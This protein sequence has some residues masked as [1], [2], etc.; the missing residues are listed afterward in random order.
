MMSPDYIRQGRI[1]ERYL[2]G[3]LTVR[4]ARE[5]EKYCLEHPEVLN[6]LPIPVRLKA[7]LARQPLEHSET[8]MFQTIPSSATRAAL[9]LADA[10]MPAEGPMGMPGLRLPALGSLGPNGTRMLVLGLLVALLAAT[11]G[12]LAYGM[13]A[14]S[15]A[16]E[17]RALREAERS[18]QLQPPATVETLRLQMSRTR[19]EQPTAVVGRS[20][21]P[22]LLEL[23]VDATESP[24]N[25]YQVTI[26]R[27]DGTRIM[28]IRRLGRDSNRQLRLALNSSAFGPGEYLLRFDGYTWRGRAEEVGWV[29]LDL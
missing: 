19:P 14:R 25:N 5:F 10:T 2:S 12:L 27:I 17:L 20:I 7:R 6:A 8:G 9:E 29:R 15:L 3:E 16:T 13:Q 23:Y 24:Y 11:G 28:Q 4:E 26:D 18:R 1:V 21:L 22:Q